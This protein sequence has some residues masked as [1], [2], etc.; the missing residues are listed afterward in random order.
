MLLLFCSD[1]TGGWVDIRAAGR[2]RTPVTCQHL[3]SF[4]INIVEMLEIFDG[5]AHLFWNVLVSA[6]VTRIRDGNY[7]P[8]LSF[9]ALGDGV[10][11]SNQ[12]RSPPPPNCGY[13]T[14]RILLLEPDLSHLLPQTSCPPFR[15]LSH[16]SEAIVCVL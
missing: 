2:N 1:R 11:C 13:F 6:T 14:L 5:S 15:Y 8:G 7:S 3:Q 16:I 10:M 9:M 4:N 12:Q